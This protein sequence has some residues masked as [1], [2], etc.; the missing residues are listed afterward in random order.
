MEAVLSEEERARRDRFVLEEDRRSFT[1]AHALLRTAL[2]RYGGLPPRAWR[3][4][5]SPAG[6]P[7]LPR[8]LAGAPPLRFSLSH[9]RSVAVCAI[10]EEIDLGVDVEDGVPRAEALA[11]AERYFTL[12]ER[13][14]LAACPPRETAVRFVEL[15]V[16]KEA[17]AK[18]VGAGLRLSLDSF[19]FSFAGARGLTF[20]GPS[21]TSRWQF[22]LA[23]LSPAT[24]VAVAASAA[25][26]RRVSWWEGGGTTAS[27]VA[28][29]RSGPE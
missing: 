23:A 28:L 24:R 7:F 6:K 11:V 5:T 18:G 20:D 16:L 26:P 8:A 2:S 12:A 22:W 17:Y 21:A 9:T 10:A 13:Q 25:S 1:A 19:G 14:A 4:E 15:W 29:L 27:R 3:F